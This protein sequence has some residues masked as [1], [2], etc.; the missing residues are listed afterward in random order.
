MIA[1][2]TIGFIYVAY[3][4]IMHSSFRKR[5]RT[6]CRDYAPTITTGGHTAG[7]G[8]A[9]MTASAGA[10]DSGAGRK[11]T[12]TLNQRLV[13]LGIL[14]FLMMGGAIA[15]LGYQNTMY[16]LDKAVGFIARAR[17]CP[18]SRAFSRIREID[19]KIDPRR[20]KSCMALSNRQDRLCDDS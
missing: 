13:L 9:T 20:G 1:I 6:A 16:L 10:A 19:T 5:K 14:A 4:S 8:S 2:P 12:R 3:L 17:D 7:P 18:D 15:F 11:A